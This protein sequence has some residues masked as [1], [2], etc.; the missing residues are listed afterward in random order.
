MFGWAKKDFIQSATT[1]LLPHDL[2]VQ[3]VEIPATFGKDRRTGE[4]IVGTQIIWRAVD[5]RFANIR[6]FDGDV[7]VIGETAPVLDRAISRIFN[8]SGDKWAA[9]GSTE[10]DFVKF[11]V[12]RINGHWFGE[13]L[14][15][16]SDWFGKVIPDHQVER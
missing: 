10:D 11:P 3:Q 9:L 16:D 8:G 1:V 4:V 6:V 13:S 12:V 2:L 15:E 5:S 7:D 14:P